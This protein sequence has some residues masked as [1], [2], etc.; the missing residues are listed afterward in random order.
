MSN[1]PRLDHVVAFGVSTHNFLLCRVDVVHAGWVLLAASPTSMLVGNV[2]AVCPE[3]VVVVQGFDVLGNDELYGGEM[4]HP[5][6]L[7][8][9]SAGVFV[10]VAWIPIFAAVPS[11]PAVTVVPLLSFVVTASI[12]LTASTVIIPVLLLDLH[13]LL[14]LKRH[15]ICWRRC[16]I[17]HSLAHHLCLLEML[18]KL[19]VGCGQS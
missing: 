16:T 10:F 14:W 2:T 13:L 18:L 17:C 12:S 3:V 7:L 19:C 11:V 6:S 5:W 9:S 8:L 15:L 4:A 1:I